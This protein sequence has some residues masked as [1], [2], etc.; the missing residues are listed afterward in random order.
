MALSNLALGRRISKTFSLNR[1]AL[2]SSLMM[3][4]YATI[5]QVVRTHPVL[6]SNTANIYV[7]YHSWQAA[8]AAT[9]GLGSVIWA[10]QILNKQTIYLW[11]SFE[12]PQ[13]DPVIHAELKIAADNA[14]TV[15]IDG[16]EIGSGSDWRTLNAYELAGKLDPGTHVLTVEGFNDTDA[17]GVIVGLRLKLASGKIMQMSSDTSW[18]VV[19]GP[20]SGWHTITRPP[21]N[22][23]EASFVERLGQAPWWAVPTTVARIQGLLPE[24]IPFWQTRRFLLLSVVG[25]GLLIVIGLYLLIQLLSQAKTHRSLQME[26]DRIARDIHDDLGSKVNQ[27]LLTGEAAQIKQAMPDT[28][29]PKICETAREIL[30]TIDEVV[31]IVNSQHDNLDDFAIQVCKYTQRFLEPTNMRFRFD[32]DE[33][34]QRKLSQ[35]MRR[36]LF[37]AVKEAMTNTVKHSHATELVIRIKLDGSTLTLFIEDNGIGFDP[38]RID[39]DCNGLANIIRRMEEI[40]GAAQIIAG[41]GHGSKICLKVSLKV[42][43]LSRFLFKTAFSPARRP[44]QPGQAAAGRITYADKP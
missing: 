23:P 2:V 41:S 26:R 36:N 34:P 6:D 17:A 3:F 39:D 27:L 21:D 38:K 9:N 15:W 29:I 10:K 16:C 24:P 43:R 32:A 18:R 4:C 7:S 40:G 30:S 25:C 37:L 12:V 13:S 5:G 8:T 42:S 33:L 22:W 31:W 14:Y 11:K 1:W 28:S 35:L 20:V 44:N 19:P